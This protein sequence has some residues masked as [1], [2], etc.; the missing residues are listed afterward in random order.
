MSQDL[1]AGLLDVSD[2]DETLGEE[3]QEIKLEPFIPKAVQSHP[4]DMAQDV[5]EDYSSVRGT[6]H[7]QQQM[8]I[9]SA[10]VALEF[11]RNTESP[12]SFEVF[13]Q[14]MDKLTQLNTGMTK[15]HQDMLDLEKKR[16]DLL[17]G[18]KESGDNTTTIINA[19]NVFYGTPSDMID[20][21]GS[22]TETR[23]NEKD[24]TPKDINSDDND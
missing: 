5:V 2:L 22:Q 21:E 7:L 9:E 23:R 24:I 4:S 14:I 8:L 3:T 15:F 1:I 6:M 20:R 13:T 18:S 11:A 10:K 19:E 16:R 17:K 12:R